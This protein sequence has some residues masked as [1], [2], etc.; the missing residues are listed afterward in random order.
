M[1]LKGNNT[2]SCPPKNMQ[3]P[4]CLRSARKD[5]NLAESISQDRKQIHVTAP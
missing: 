5:N 2:L 4:P 3:P 1:G